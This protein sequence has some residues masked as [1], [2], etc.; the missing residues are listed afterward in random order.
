MQW[1]Q[2]IKCSYVV[3]YQI[4]R[5]PAY[6]LG[7][8]DNEA[9]DTTRSPS[10]YTWSQITLALTHNFVT[11]GKV[12]GK[13]YYYYS[14]PSHSSNYKYPL[15]Y[16]IFTPWYGRHW[17]NEKCAR[18]NTETVSDF[19]SRAL[20]H[21]ETSQCREWDIDLQKNLLNKCFYK[22]KSES[23]PLGELRIRTDDYEWTQT[24]LVVNRMS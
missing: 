13:P 6:R 23:L 5:N 19:A 8:H 4:W 7:R 22:T 17:R 1:G 11:L 15:F 12:N 3:T 2:Q 14:F 24:R 10:H 9:T 21:Q 18:W 20:T 16:P